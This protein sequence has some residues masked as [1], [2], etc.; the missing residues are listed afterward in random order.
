MNALLCLLLGASAVLVQSSTIAGSKVINATIRTTV[1]TNVAPNKAFVQSKTILTKVAT[2]LDV[3]REANATF[4]SASPTCST[5][6]TLFYNCATA[7]IFYRTDVNWNLIALKL[8]NKSSLCSTVTSM[9]LTN[10]NY[11]KALK[12]GLKETGYSSSSSSAALDTI[13]NTTASSSET[14]GNL[15]WAAAT[16]AYSNTLKQ[17]TLSI[18]P[19]VSNA[20]PCNFVFG[21]RTI[22]DYATTTST[23]ASTSYTT[24]TSTTTGTTTSSANGVV[25]GAGAGAAL[26]LLN[27]T[28]DN[29][30]GRKLQAASKASKGALVGSK[31]PVTTVTTPRTPGSSL[32]SSLSL[33]TSFTVVR[34]NL[35]TLST[36]KES[37]ATFVSVSQTFFSTYFATNAKSPGTKTS[38]KFGF[39]TTKAFI[40]TVTITNISS[41]AN[42]NTISS[43]LLNNISGNAT[44]SSPYIA[45]LNN[46]TVR[47]RQYIQQVMTY[48]T[49]P[50]PPPMPPSP[51]NGTAVVATPVS[52]TMGFATPLLLGSANTSI[53]LNSI[54]QAIASKAVVML[55]QVTFPTFAQAPASRHLLVTSYIISCTVNAANAAAAAQV[56]SGLNSASGNGLL[57]AIQAALPKGFSGLITSVALPPG[58]IQAGT[59]PT[60][61]P[62]GRVNSAAPATSLSLTLF[63]LAAALLCSF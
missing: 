13:I 5:G 52:L 62:N 61:K 8:L 53:L 34:S 21:N 12:S 36:S 2:S 37:L 57:A 44:G 60:V 31:A 41:Q 23:T 33:N 6:N 22:M 20:P 25:T 48:M 19:S 26:I 47:P 7:G 15:S 16:F 24:D 28:A 4:L 63:A 17:V 10:Y 29:L 18:T 59:T 42:V 58:G 30:P 51:A 27:N 39:N 40:F 1:N 3:W 9:Y 32:G 49:S 50:P 43:L 38:I 54:R 46:A 14:L 55:N 45:A 11:T 56:A 35:T